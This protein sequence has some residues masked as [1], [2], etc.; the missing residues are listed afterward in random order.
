M[1]MRKKP[2]PAPRKTEEIFG[3][4]AT[5]LLFPKAYNPPALATHCHAGKIIAE[6]TLGDEDD[7]PCP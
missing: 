6:E 7:T 5:R 2:D 3:G 1:N 4:D